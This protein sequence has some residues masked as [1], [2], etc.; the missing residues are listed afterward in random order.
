MKA[1]RVK[2]TKLDKIA[3]KLRRAFQAESK[4]I[5]DIGNLLI[6]AR[7]LLEIEHGEWMT[8]LKDNF[9]LSYRTAMRYIGAA[10]YCASKSATVA[11]LEML[12]PGVLYRP[13]DGSFTPEEEAG[14]LVATNEG[15][16]I[17][18]ERASEIC[19]A[20]TPPREPEE[21]L[22]EPEKAAEPESPDDDDLDAILDGPPPELP[23][24]EPAPAVDFLLPT[25][26]QAIAKLKELS[27]KP[28][29]KFLGSVHS[30]GDIEAVAEFLVHV[31]HLKGKAKPKAAA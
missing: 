25:F 14:I 19:A 2:K 3:E 18:R 10:D 5:V 13:A 21:E 9:N 31:S 1:T 30:S 27:T 28:S 16:R 6:N 8:W 4:S 7:E 26:D 15:L 29:E 20:L 23:P 11:N 12:S 22:G 24:T 17:G